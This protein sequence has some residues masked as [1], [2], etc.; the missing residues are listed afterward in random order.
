MKKFKKVIA[1]M[2]VMSLLSAMVVGCSG[3]GKEAGNDEAG[4]GNEV[5]SEAWPSSGLNIIVG[6]GPGGSTDIFARILAKHLEKDLGQTVI[7]TN[8]EGGGGAVGYSEALKSKADGSNVVVSN[9]SLLTLGGAGN[10]EFGYEDFDNL[11]R[12]IVEDEAVCVGKDA[13]WDSVPELIEYAKANP[14][15]LKVGYAGMGGFT[16]LASSQFIEF[17]GMEVE[18]VGY[19]SGAE[20]VTALLGGFV[21]LVIQQVGEVYS[22][23]EAEELKILGIMGDERHPLLPD[24]PILSE[25]GIDLELYQWRGISGPSGM[26]EEAKQGWI[27]A[28]DRVQKS[29]EF[30]KEVTEVLLANVNYISGDEFEA[31]LEDEASWIYPLI[32]ELGL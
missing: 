3:G 13:P 27:E 14:G 7:V 6:Y 16:H 21:D 10:V 18:G 28:M 24:T 26:P 5:E 9:G 12:V 22:Q 23:Y 31:W 19:G 29:E 2:V 30:R 15:E 11:G 1:L 25:D 8:V 4:A 32:E 20:A 17:N